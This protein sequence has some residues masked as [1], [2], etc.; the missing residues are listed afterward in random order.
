M[1]VEGKEIFYPS[2]YRIGIVFIRRLLCIEFQ[3]YFGGLCTSGFRRE[4]SGCKLY[5]AESYRTDGR[6]KQRKIYLGTLPG[7]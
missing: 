6:V 7:N 4:G 5:L 1:V 3:L 2:R